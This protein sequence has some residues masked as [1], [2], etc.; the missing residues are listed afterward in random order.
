MKG[1]DYLIILLVEEVGPSH[2]DSGKHIE[3]KQKEM[4]LHKLV[5][6][7]QW[8]LSKDALDD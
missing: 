7:L 5:L 2:K 1:V 8:V 6:L 3:N 4:L